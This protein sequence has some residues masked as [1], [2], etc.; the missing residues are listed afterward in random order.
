MCYEDEDAD[1][2]DNV[3]QEKYHEYIAKLVEAC[4]WEECFDIVKEGL[5]KDCRDYELYF[6]LGEY[7]YNHNHN[8]EQAYLC[9][10][11]AL[12]YCHE[13]ADREYIINV[14]DELRNSGIKVNPVS[15]VIVSYNSADVMKACINSIR[16]NNMPDTY[17]LIVVDN[18]SNDEVREWLEQQKDIRLIENNDNMG[19]GYA[20]NQGIKA[21]NP[22]DDIFLLNNDT[23]VTANAIFW[24]RMGLYGSNKTGAVSSLSNADIERKYNKHYSSLT[25]FI[26][27]GEKNNIPELNPH[28]KRVW[29]SGYALM[30][31][32]KVIDEIGLLDLRYGMGYYE[33]DD[34]GVRIQYAGY[35]CI[36]CNNSFIFHWESLSFNKNIDNKVKLM[37]QNRQVFKEK[38]GFDINYYSYARYEIIKL[39]EDEKDKPIKVLEIGCGCGA[40][41]FSIEYQWPNSEVKGIEL[42]ENVVRIGAN[43]CDIIQGDIETM[44]IPYEKGFFDYVILGD[45]LEHLYSP[46]KVLEKIRPYMKKDASLIVSVPNIM[47]KSVIMSLLKGE[48]HYEDAG[49]LDR[50]HIKFFTIK[51]II[52][53]LEKCGF[54]T[55]FVGMVSNAQVGV[56]ISNEEE[57]EFQNAVNCISGAAHYQQFEAYQYILRAT[58]I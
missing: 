8:A 31:K 48:F 28:E 3:H 37:R 4:R 12:F 54:K 52:E 53:L 34:I 40:T 33:D 7:Y 38:W 24:L 36:L 58:N 14:M 46:D 19:F 5:K 41:L 9:Y 35:Q 43:N 26:Q 44:N 30:I 42:I 57:K 16:V 17:E 32:R 27:V 23:F 1:M 20:S 15:I 50:T 39:I 2:I 49:I 29:L 13:E 25:E 22:D 10:E 56:N 45:V 11:N 47:N 18:A 51:T 21:S 55:D 6:A